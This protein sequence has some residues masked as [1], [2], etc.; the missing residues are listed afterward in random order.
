M[1][2]GTE[3]TKNKSSNPSPSAS[4][5]IFE[6]FYDDFLKGLFLCQKVVIL[7]DTMASWILIPDYFSSRIRLTNSH[8]SPLITLFA[9]C[10]ASAKVA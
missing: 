4:Y 7:Y 1:L 6:P 5:S 3:K 8:Q 10:E 9:K 2:L